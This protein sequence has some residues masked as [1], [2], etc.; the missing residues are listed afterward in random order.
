[1]YTILHRH[2]IIPK[3]I[4]G[5]DDPSNLIELTIEE[6]AEA[7]RKLYEEHGRWQDRVAWLSLA[8]IMK[9]EERIYEIVSNSNKGN[10]S[11]YSHSDETSKIT[12]SRLGEKNPMFGK[13]SHLKGTKRPG[14]GGRKKGTS[15]SEEE[16]AVQEKIR[17]A[18]GYYDFTQCPERNKKISEAHKGRTGSAQGK[19]WFN[20]GTNET[21]AFACPEGFIV[22]R[23]PGRN[24]NKKGMGWYNNSVVNK[25]YRVGEV[26]EGFVRGR[27]SRK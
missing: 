19:T 2:H 25:Q 26:P 14:I 8:G 12:E 11:N 17:N 23:K 7:H 10:P 4:G 1:M 24:S 6:H 9:D 3:H 15:W 13:V 27:V 18:P 21:Y 22:G 16:R 20:D 5:S